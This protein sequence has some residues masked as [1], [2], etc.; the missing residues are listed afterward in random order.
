MTIL[1]AK[2]GIIQKCQ[3]CNSKNIYEILDLGHSG[4]CDSLLTK[5][6][7]N[8]PEKSYPLKLLRCKKCHLLQLNFVVDNKEVFHLDYPYKSGITKTLKDLLHST[9][10]YCVNNFKF[11]HKPLVID[12]G[13]NDGTLLEG[14]KKH[15]F[16]VLGVEPTNIAKLAN[17]K[18]IKT[19]QK[20]FDKSTENY[21]KKN[22]KKAE[23]ITGTNIFAHINKL[24]TLMKGVKN[25]LDSKNGIFVT[26]SHYAVNILDEMQFDSIYHEH[27][28]FYLLKPIILLLKKYGFKVIDAVKIPNYAGSIRVTATLNKNIKPKP[29]VLKILNE[30]KRR[31]FYN[32]K[33]YD[34]YGRKVEKIKKDLNRMLWKM[35]LKN[36]RIVGVGCPGRSI[37]LLAYCNITNQ[38][39]DYIAEQNSSL[40][41]NMF[42]PTT[43]IKVID[44]KYM[45]KKQP[46]YALVLSWHY[47][48]NVM[49][50]LKKKGF[51]GKFIMPLPK[52][53]IVN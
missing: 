9:S 31:G 6:D 4:L 14:F 42:T 24:N 32:S 27:L 37:T 2:P 34:Q 45:I 48:K 29:S 3:I 13:S 33:K 11:S 53:R 18:G 17:K 36:K 5:K 51:K 20:Y 15:D 22:F 35:K 10:R 26:E 7:I 44:E 23:I 50:N 25:L 12:I 30:E 16:K 19:I 49:N 43:H 28:R 47:G 21:I 39:I 46:D 40:K 38:L 52:P 8:S 1:D 41:L